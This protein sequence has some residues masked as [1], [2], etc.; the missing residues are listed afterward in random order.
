MPTPI[1]TTARARAAAAT[2]DSAAP[3]PTPAA[4][5]SP[6]GGVSLL[7][8][9]SAAALP[10]LGQL[11]ILMLRANQG[12]RE[13]DRKAEEQFEREERAADAARLKEMRDKA[14]SALA[15]GM[16]SGALQLGSGAASVVAGARTFK[17]MR[18][19][20]EHHVPLD[21]DPGVQFAQKTEKI[22]DASGKALDGVRTGVEAL[23]R[24]SGDRAQAR[25]VEHE[26]TSK[27]ARRAADRVKAEQDALKQSDARIMQLSAEIARAHQDCLRAALLK[28]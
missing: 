5:A 4:G 7:P 27:A 23:G 25:I 18:D 15:S 12:A 21:K 14:D 22:V 11:H 20:D 13:A 1:H 28:M 6:E 16:L 2:D 10:V 24:A 19:A 17:A 26:N 3:N 8:G 9:A